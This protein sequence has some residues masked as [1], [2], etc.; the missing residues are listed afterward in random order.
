MFVSLSNTMNHLIQNYETILKT[1]AGFPINYTP[2][3]QIRRPKLSNMECVAL[4]LT[5][6]FMSIDSENQLFRMSKD[7]DLEHKIDRTVFNRRRKMLFSLTEHVRWH[8]VKVLRGF[9]YGAIQGF[10]RLT[11]PLVL[12]IQDV[13]GHFSGRCSPAL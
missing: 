11:E 3:L 12:R 8:L 13:F 9:R 2:Y 5:A 10:L 1:L 7:T 6:E 4:G